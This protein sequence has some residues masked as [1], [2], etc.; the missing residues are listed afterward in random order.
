MKD[1]RNTYKGVYLMPENILDDAIDVLKDVKDEQETQIEDVSTKDEGPVN[2]SVTVE[3]KVNDEKK[4]EIVDSTVETEATEVQGVNASASEIVI[5]KQVRSM[6]DMIDVL[7]TDLEANKKTIDDMKA[8][9]A[10]LFFKP[11]ENETV[12]KDTAEV[13]DELAKFF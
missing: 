3:E 2:V 9:I 4:D 6:Q 1:L 11:T 10:E 7:K 5:M 8:E 13:F 12:K